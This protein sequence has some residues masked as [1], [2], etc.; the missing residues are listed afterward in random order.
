MFDFD[1]ERSAVE[2]LE[3]FAHHVL[4]APILVDDGNEYA[5]TLE[6]DQVSSRSTT[7]KYEELKQHPSN[8]MM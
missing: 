8:S 4:N 7:K 2:Q 3:T 6:G 1:D 5:L